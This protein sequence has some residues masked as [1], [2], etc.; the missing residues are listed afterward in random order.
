[1]S[2]EVA[3]DGKQTLVVDLDAQCNATTALGIA[4]DQTPSSYD[5]LV[6]RVSVAEAARPAGP[7]NL[8]IVPANGDLAGASVEL[9]RTDDYEYR[10]RD[11]LGPVRERFS[12]TLL[13]CPPS[14]GPITVNALVAADRVI[15]PVQAEYLALEGLVQ[16]LDTLKLV[17]RELNPSLTMA[18]VV[19]T[20]HDDRTRLSQDVERELRQHLPAPVFKT[21]IPRSIRVAE[22][23]SYGIPVGQHDPRS[24]GA[25]AYAAFAEEVT[26][27]G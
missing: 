16:F 13:D 10:L 14:L 2:S 27:L 19:I 23:P 18:G 11:G 15:V 3:R 7:D 12:Y 1:M 24:P 21:V 22:A 26:A 9:P 4:K 17:Q 6:G 25:E 5:C 8:W 20:M